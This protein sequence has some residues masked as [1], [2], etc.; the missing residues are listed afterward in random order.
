MSECRKECGTR[1]QENMFAIR[2]TVFF[3]HHMSPLE[4]FSVPAKSRVCD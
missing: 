1:N 3:G 4:G 2:D